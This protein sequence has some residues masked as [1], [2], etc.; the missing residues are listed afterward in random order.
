[1]KFD[2]DLD[3][4][5]ALDKKLRLLEPRVQKRVLQGAVTSAIREGR[6]EIKKK[7]PKSVEQS[8][9][10]LKYGRLSQNLKVKRLKRTK[11]NEKMARVD[12]GKAF[13]ALFYELGTRSQPA[14]PFMSPA[15]KDAIPK[16]TQ[17]LMER[18]SKGIIKEVNKIQ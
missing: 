4:F 14:R 17:K 12:T 3:G 13:W 2:M 1:M 6:K 5:D 15:F 8:P 16:M 18:L 7:A 10:S 11:P 9:N